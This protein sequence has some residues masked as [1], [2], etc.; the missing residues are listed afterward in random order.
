MASPGLCSARLHPC[1]SRHSRSPRYGRGRKPL[2]MPASTPGTRPV[3]LLIYRSRGRTP[4]RP[5]LSQGLIDQRG[6]RIFF[7]FRIGPR[8]NKDLHRSGSTPRR[9]N[10]GQSQSQDGSSF[11]LCI[12]HCLD[13]GPPRSRPPMSMFDAISSMHLLPRRPSVPHPYHIVSLVVDQD[14][15][16]STRRMVV[17]SCSEPAYPT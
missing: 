14:T 16:L 6:E 3:A 8:P 17:P 15:P 12:V 4:S 10:T 7:H 5:G 1:S 9:S 13:R 11:H 2:N